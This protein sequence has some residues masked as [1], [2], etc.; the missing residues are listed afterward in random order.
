[1][2]GERYSSSEGLVHPDVG[3]AQGTSVAGASESSATSAIMGIAMVG[4]LGGGPRLA[5]RAARV[6]IADGYGAR[7]RARDGRLRGRIRRRGD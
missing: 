6:V 1:M 5:M 2:T 3:D 7:S 4:L